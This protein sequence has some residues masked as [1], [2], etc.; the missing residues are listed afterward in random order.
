MAVK[1]TWVSLGNFGPKTAL[2]CG[3]LAGI[4][5][6]RAHIHQFPE[7]VYVKEGEM[8]LTVDGVT[9]TMRAGDIAIIAPFRV[10][11]FHTP[12][13]VNRW[14]CVFSGDFVSHFL[15][16]EELYGIGERCVFH[17]SDELIAFIEGK[18]IDSHEEFFDLNDGIIRSFK[19]MF[20]GIYEEYMRK[21]KPLQTRPHGQALSSVLLYIAEHCREQISLA[22]IGAALGYSPKY[23]SLCLS[24]IEGMNLYGLVNAFRADLAK[25]LLIRTDLRVIDIAMECG[26]ASEKSFH[27]AFRQV[28]G[29][30][31]GKYRAE[32]RKSR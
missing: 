8:L 9:E 25:D 2:R 28:M 20:A 3:F 15:T 29:T 24:S 12:E 5:D 11:S 23:I 1:Q 32:K 7:I 31:P 26:Y 10:H 22:S 19:A 30:T 4:Y 21:E 27:R 13:Y 16:S 6:F 14:I 17:A 18:M